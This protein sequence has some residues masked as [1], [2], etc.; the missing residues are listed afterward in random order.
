MNG[1]EIKKAD[2]RQYKIAKLLHILDTGNC[3]KW[4]PSFVLFL[5]TEVVEN[6]HLLPTV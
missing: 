6:K 4:I 5:Y 2:H 3:N 1:C